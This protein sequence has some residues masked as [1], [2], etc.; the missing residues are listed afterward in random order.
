MQ[1]S[2]SRS[3]GTLSDRHETHMITLDCSTQR[4]DIY[5]TYVVVENVDNPHD[6]KTIHVT[7]RMIVSA[8][9][10]ISHYFSVIV[11]TKVKY[12]QSKFGTSE[13]APGALRGPAAD[14]ALA[15]VEADV[16][17]AGGERALEAA[18]DAKRGVW[19]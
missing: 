13:L 15:I 14:A 9:V 8:D 6:L 18:R 2:I 10:P 11:D 19:K 1:V 3:S 4:L 5:S 12:D 17:D 16:A 7:M